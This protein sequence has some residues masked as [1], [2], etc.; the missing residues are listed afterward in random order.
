MSEIDLERQVEYWRW[1][2]SKVELPS[3]FTQVLAHFY[4]VGWWLVPAIRSWDSTWRMW[5]FFSGLP[6][7]LITGW[8]VS[9]GL[10]HSSKAPVP[11]HFEWTADLHWCFIQHCRP[12]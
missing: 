1:E 5:A 10:R 3:R 4:G 6:W 11:S 9:T 2:P 7:I 8:V 12:G